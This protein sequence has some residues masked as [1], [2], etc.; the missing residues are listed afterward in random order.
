M[1]EFCPQ[2]GS[3]RIGAFRFCRQCRFDFDAVAEASVPTAE[4]VA[5]PP[6]VSR[7]SPRRWLGAGVSVVVGLG[8][9]AT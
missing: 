6:T 5:R 4:S 2:C 7:L 8:S 1:S 3:A 9:W